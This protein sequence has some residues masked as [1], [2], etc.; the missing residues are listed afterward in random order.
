MAAIRWLALGQLKG[1]N[2]IYIVDPA[3][4]LRKGWRKGI[5]EVRRWEGFYKA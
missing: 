3:T 2:V 1:D 5:G 4:W